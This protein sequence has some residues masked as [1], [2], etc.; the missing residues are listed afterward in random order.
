MRRWLKLGDI[1]DVLSGMMF[2]ELAQM[3]VDKKEFS[4]YYAS[5]FSDPSSSRRKRAKARIAS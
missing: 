1:N 3:L 2:S 4:R 5:L